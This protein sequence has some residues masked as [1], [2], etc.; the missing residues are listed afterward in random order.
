M[1]QV[2]VQD[3]PTAHCRCWQAQSHRVCCTLSDWGQT[4]FQ[5]NKK[6]KQKHPTCPAMQNVPIQTILREMWK[7]PN[8]TSCNKLT[9]AH[10][11]DNIGQSKFCWHA[12]SFHAGL[13][14]SDEK[15]WLVMCNHSLTAQSGCS[16]LSQVISQQCP[17]WQDHWHE[18]HVKDHD[19]RSKS[20][21][22]NP[23]SGRT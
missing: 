16:W 8:L 19:T 1:K 2:A 23:R 21:T 13:S 14:S 17:G 6:P 3:T 5:P 22:S 12:I 18:N 10:N 15:K 4:F 9:F 11:F 7:K 20:T